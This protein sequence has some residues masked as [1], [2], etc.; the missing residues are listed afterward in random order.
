MVNLRTK[1]SNW[2]QACVVALFCR[3]KN[4][5]YI[6]NLAI[7]VIVRAMIAWEQVELKISTPTRV[8]ANFNLDPSSTAQI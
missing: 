6:K 4:R 8:A 7:T 2:G 5:N 3:L 1:K